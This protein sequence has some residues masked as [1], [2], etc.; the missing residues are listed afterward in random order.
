AWIGRNY[1][2][3]G[4]SGDNH[5]ML[6]TL[7]QGIYPGMMYENNPNSLGYP[8][9]FDP[10]YTQTNK[11]LKDVL[12]EIGRNFEAQPGAELC[13]YI[14]GK[15]IMLWSWDMIAGA[16]DI[17]IYPT[18]VSP[19]QTR[20]HPI[21]LATHVLMRGLHWALIV[22]ALFGCILAWFPIGSRYYNS[23]QILAFKAISLLLVYNTGVLMLGA[24]F[25]RYSIPFLPLVYVIAIAT[26]FPFANYVNKLREASHKNTG[27]SSSSSSGINP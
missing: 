18:Q 27:G 8:Y 19:Y 3:L 4:R 5:L 13:W 10:R 11:N 26:A 16:G 6:A 9:R 2:T 23:V 1:L 22:T 14:L 12:T 25:P 21:F 7:H 15:P 17:F 24:P 20:S